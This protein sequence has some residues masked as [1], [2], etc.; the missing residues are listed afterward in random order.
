[1]LIVL[2]IVCEL[3][4]I[5]T[6]LDYSLINIIGLSDG[7]ALGRAS[8]AANENEINAGVMGLLPSLS[9]SNLY[10]RLPDATES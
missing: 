7:Y 6:S 8:S 3:G 1:M 4:P 10:E 2:L 9:D 5:F